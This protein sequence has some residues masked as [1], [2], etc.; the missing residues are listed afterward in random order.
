MSKTK[1]ETNENIMTMERVFKAP[2]QK[3]WDAFTI[4]EQFVKW[5]GPRGWQT[6]CKEFDF[7]EGGTCHYAMKCEDESQGEWFG[8]T[9]WGRMT[10]SNIRPIDTY[11]Y[12]DY[13]SDEAGDIN[14]EMAETKVEMKFEEVE[15]GT[16]VMSICTYSD[17]AALQSVMDMG[18]A[19]GITQTWDRLAEAVEGN[20]GHAS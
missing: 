17:A 20:V 8:Q 14:A 12:I 19:D 11:D 3:V 15:G 5:W 2:R 10:F 6:T 18:M 4:E 13:F 7:S 9:S 1:L 16:R